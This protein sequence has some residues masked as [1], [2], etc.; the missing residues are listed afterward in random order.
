[1]AN[2]GFT[3]G[4]TAGHADRRWVFEG[5]GLTIVIV[6]LAIA[7]TAI[8]PRF[9]SLTNF[10]NILTQASFII[11][12]AVGMTFVITSAGIDLSVGSAAALITVV[13]FDLIKG[14]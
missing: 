14:G 11:V 6:V 1:M 10:V 9:A 8:N 4:N 5:L 12:M 3:G 2:G 7:F 13:A